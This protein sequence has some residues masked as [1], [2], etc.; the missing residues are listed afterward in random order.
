MY[1]KK[2]IN[3]RPVPTFKNFDELFTKGL[4]QF[5]GSDFVNNVAPSAN[6]IE[7]DKAYHIELIAAGFSKENFKLGI[8]KGLLT[9]SAEV[10][11]EKADEKVKYT[12]REFRKNSFKRS[13][14]LPDTVDAE[15]ISAT[16]E[17]GILKV[18]LPKDETVIVKRTIS[19][20]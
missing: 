11:E 13:F 17:S 1:T 4:D 5:F 6:V 9:I 20:S 3:R 14:Q 18:V 7:S 15:A 19:V 12:R 16:Y 10:A 8:D 2:V